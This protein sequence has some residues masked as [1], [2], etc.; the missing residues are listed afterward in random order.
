MTLDCV[1][2]GAFSR[3]WDVGVV[4]SSTGEV[5]GGLVMGDV[6]TLASGSRIQARSWKPRSHLCTSAGI[7]VDAENRDRLLAAGFRGPSR[8]RNSRGCYLVAS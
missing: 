4:P 5:A 8:A 7:R 1:V 6:G 3:L 2:H